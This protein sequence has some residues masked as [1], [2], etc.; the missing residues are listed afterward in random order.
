MLIKITIFLFCVFITG[1]I[2]PKDKTFSP[3]IHDPRPEKTYWEEEPETKIYTPSGKRQERE[4]GRKAPVQMDT[5][6]Q[7]DG[8]AVEITLNKDNAR[9]M[10]MSPSDG[11]DPIVLVTGKGITDSVYVYRAEM[12]RAENNRVLKI[13]S[14]INT[15]TSWVHVLMIAR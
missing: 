11:I 3:M 15:D 9:N 2:A 8:G 1:T 5:L 7:M 12:V 13:T 4:R 10:I 6:V 14:S